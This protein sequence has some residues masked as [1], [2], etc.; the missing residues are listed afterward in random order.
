[1]FFSLKVS[2]AGEGL[3]VNTLMIPMGKDRVM[4]PVIF[5]MHLDREWRRA[6]RKG[7]NLWSSPH[8]R[9]REKQQRKRAGPTAHAKRQIAT[10]LDSFVQVTCGSYSKSEIVLPRMRTEKETVRG[11][12][13][14]MNSKHLL[15]SYQF[16]LIGL[17]LTFFPQETIPCTRFREIERRLH[18]DGED[19]KHACR[20]T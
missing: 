20:R 3:L 9:R 16:D 11:T 17:R 8:P 4:S 18:F 7:L 2:T 6:A 15:H 5:T 19:T 1:V 14:C 12:C 10:T 13:L